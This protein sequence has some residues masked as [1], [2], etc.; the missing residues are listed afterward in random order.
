MKRTV[1]VVSVFVAALLAGIL[2]DL[3]VRPPPAAARE[4]APTETKEPFIPRLTGTGGTTTGRAAN[5]Q[6]GSSFWGSFGRRRETFMQQE[7]GMPLDMQASEGITGFAAT[8]P[9]LGSEP[10]PVPL[11][12]YD[13]AN[14]T[15]LFQFQD[16]RVSADCCPSPFSSDR[17]CV[18]LTNEQIKQFETRGGNRHSA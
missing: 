13:M 6:S 10:K 1:V 7:V 16:N 8:S 18:C 12:P 2:F 14:D 3:F 17:G 15:E 4:E 9:L 11:K 5:T